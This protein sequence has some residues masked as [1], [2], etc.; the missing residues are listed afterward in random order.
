MPFP[1]CPGSITNNF[2]LNGKS[3]SVEQFF[4]IIEKIN[5]KYQERSGVIP[6]GEV[7]AEL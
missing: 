7:L 3:M 5:E 2:A 1:A 4:L 6:W